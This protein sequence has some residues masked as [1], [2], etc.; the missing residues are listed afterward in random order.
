MNDNPNVPA[1]MGGPN[2]EVLA[3]GGKHIRTAIASVFEALG[4]ATGLEAWARS[5][6]DRMDDFYTKL[7]PKIIPKEHIVD[8]RR[9]VDDLILELDGGVPAS[10]APQPQNV[11]DADFEE[12]EGHWD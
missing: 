3:L 7:M 1:V 11:V 9:S 4:G 12:D 2:G 8:D 6:G 5:S 10:L